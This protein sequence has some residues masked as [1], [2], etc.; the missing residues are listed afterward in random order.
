MSR[1]LSDI[2][3]SAVQK[4]NEYLNLNSLNNDS[5]MSIINAITYTVSS[6]V[7]SFETL[8][9]TFMVDFA[10]IMAGRIH[11][12]AAYYANAMKKWQYGD[13][14]VVDESGTSFYYQ[15]EDSSKCLITRVSYEEQYNTDYK[16]NVL[17]LKV[18]KGE[19][20]S[21]EQLSYEELLSARA[22]MNQIKFAGVKTRVVSRKGDVLVPRLTVYYDG[23]ISEDEMYTNIETA[24]SDYI[25]NMSFDSNVYVQKIIDAIQSA[26]HV[27]DVY[28][29]PMAA[30]G[31]EQGIFIAK[32]DDD[33]QIE[34]GGL[35]KIERM[36]KT[37][38]G[39]LKQSTREG[40]EADFPTYRE[41]IVLKVEGEE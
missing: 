9:D 38:S 22:Y 16:D 41:A 30:Q 6:V 5:K 18:A 34:Q 31:E 40:A 2:Y 17:I 14:L 20:N 12:T 28:M 36:T 29:D 32:Y 37:S 23:A 26:E 39:F 10:N 21:L 11:G 25:E 27:M 8:L 3:N 35:Q 7:Y 15:N 4:R 13:S 33:N 1:T 19:G 24:L